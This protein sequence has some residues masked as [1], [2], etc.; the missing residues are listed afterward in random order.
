MDFR[1]QA[2]GHWSH[3]SGKSEWVRDGWDIR[4][5]EG[6]GTAIETVGRPLHPTKMTA[7]G[8]KVEMLWAT[9][10]EANKA[11][12]AANAGKKEGISFASYSND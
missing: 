8:A 5:F 11:A 3:E 10:E 9:E 6:T 1:S 4:K 12:A 2:Q 7:W